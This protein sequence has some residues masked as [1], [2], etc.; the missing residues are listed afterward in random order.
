MYNIYNILRPNKTRN[1]RDSRDRYRYGLMRIRFFLSFRFQTAEISLSARRSKNTVVLR[2][3]LGC[4]QQRKD[5]TMAVQFFFNFPSARL[6]FIFFFRYTFV[7]IHQPANIYILYIMYHNYLYRYI[8]YTAVA[9]RLEESGS[10]NGN[11]RCPGNQFDHLQRT[12]DNC[13]R[14]K[15]IPQRGRHARTRCRR[16]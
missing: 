5:R 10:L 9:A 11:S 15:R 7:S 16:R 2:R 1:Y 14:R 6:F 12:Y 8:L 3:G 13:F 4:V